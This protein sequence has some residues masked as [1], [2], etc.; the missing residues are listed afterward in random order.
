MPV[1]NQAPGDTEGT[2]GYRNIDKIFAP[3]EFTVKRKRWTWKKEIH[4][5]TSLPTVESILKKSGGRGQHWGV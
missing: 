4:I 3:K 5:Y 2:W 1:M